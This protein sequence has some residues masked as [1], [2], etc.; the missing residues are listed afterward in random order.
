MRVVHVSQVARKAAALAQS[1]FLKMEVKFTSRSGG[2]GG[3]LQRAK[4]ATPSPQTGPLFPF[5]PSIR[6]APR[7]VILG[8]SEVLFLPRSATVV[9][10][11]RSKHK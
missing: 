11:I 8:R 4:E 7:D 6:L 5:R 9:V 1:H 2:G 10:A 3:V